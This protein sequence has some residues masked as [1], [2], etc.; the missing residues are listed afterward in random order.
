MAVR[1]PRDETES[2]QITPRERGMGI[3]MQTFDPHGTQTRTHTHIEAEAGHQCSSLSPLAAVAVPRPL[4]K[5][6]CGDRAAQPVTRL[7]ESDRTQAAGVVDGDGTVR[8]CHHH[9]Q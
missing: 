3:F 2:V 7:L 4:A 5:A 8:L 9:N 6:A 1:G